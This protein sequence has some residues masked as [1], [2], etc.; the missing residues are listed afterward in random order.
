MA[1]FVL[2]RRVLFAFQK[3]YDEKFD[4]LEALGI[5]SITN[6]S[7]WGTPLVPVLKSNDKIRI[8]GDNKSTFA[9]A[10]R[11]TVFE[12]AGRTHFH[13]TGL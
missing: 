13:E 10:C 6:S 12:A 5:I 8:C 1:K 11:R 9:A 3:Q 7:D 4:Q 2:A